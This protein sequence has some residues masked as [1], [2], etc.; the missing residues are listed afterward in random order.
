M[1]NDQQKVRIFTLNALQVRDIEVQ[2]T[3]L[4]FDFHKKPEKHGTLSVLVSVWRLNDVTNYL[5]F[6]WHFTLVYYY[7]TSVFY[8]ILLDRLGIVA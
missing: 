2:I 6:L 3:C 7:F 4:C 1:Y 5:W 8:S